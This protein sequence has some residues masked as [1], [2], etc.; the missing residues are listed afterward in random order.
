LAERIP[1]DCEPLIDLL[2]DQ[3]PEAVQEVA[4]VVDQISLALAPLSTVLGE[5]DNLIVGAG[6]V[7][8]IVADRAALPP[9]PSQVST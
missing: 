4:L 2:P 1:V 9:V 6:P 7:T 8:E 3:V 5:A